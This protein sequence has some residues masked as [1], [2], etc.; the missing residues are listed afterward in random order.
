MVWFK[1][2]AKAN[3]PEASTKP[4]T[5][6]VKLPPTDSPASVS[7]TVVPPTTTDAAWHA[8]DQAALRADLGI[9]QR[10]VQQQHLGLM[11]IDAA[12]R[13]AKT[14]IDGLTAQHE[15]GVGL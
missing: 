8:D 1:V 5:S 11:E 3:V 13:G 12:R 2:C 7:V 4:L 14:Y 6:I 9:E 10:H 15:S